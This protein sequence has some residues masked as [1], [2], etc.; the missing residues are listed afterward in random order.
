MIFLWFSGT[1]I[2]AHW[3][4]EATSLWEKYWKRSRESQETRTILWQHLPR[5]TLLVHC[6]EW[7]D[8]CND[9]NGNSFNHASNNRGDGPPREQAAHQRGDAGG[10][11]HQKGQ[12]IVNNLIIS[13]IYSCQLQW[14][15][16]TRRWTT[17]NKDWWKNEEKKE[18]N[19]L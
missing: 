8:S 12:L 14:G 5:V 19:S 3:Y 13:L 16:V 7:L 15:R 9:R 2:T 1:V 4:F 6:L 18:R 17:T 10:E 11:R